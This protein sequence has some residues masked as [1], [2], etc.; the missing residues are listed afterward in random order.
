M[1]VGVGAAQR[2]I[3]GNHIGRQQV[4]DG[5]AELAGDPAEAAAQCQAG[6][7]GGRVDAGRHGEA[8]FLRFAIDL[9]EG[10]A[11]LHP[12]APTFWIDPHGGHGREIDHQ[13][14]IAHGASADVV[15]ATAHGHQ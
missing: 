9:P 2:R 11:W 3:G 5:Q 14:A 15:A 10:S 6:D 7:A 8:E 1:R 4:V 13:P 12:G